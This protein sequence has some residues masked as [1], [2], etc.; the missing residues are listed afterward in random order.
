VER[1]LT[2]ASATWLLFF[3]QGGASVWSTGDEYIV[4]FANPLQTGGDVFTFS[5]KAPLVGDA[6]LI[7]AE[8][9]KIN[10]FPNP[11]YGFHEV[12][13]SR[14]DKFVTFNHLPR[15]ANIRIFNLGG[16]MVRL[17]KKDDESQFIQWNL[18]NQNRFPV[19]SGIYIVHIDMGDVGTKILKLALI[20]EEQILRNY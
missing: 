9:E 3:E 20:Q 7:K 12:E 19:A 13:P 6:G 5:T 1:S 14:F 2:D 4:R 11:Y 15:K 17:L 8:V 16:Q 18:Q 10:V